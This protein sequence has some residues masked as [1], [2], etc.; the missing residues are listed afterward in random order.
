MEKMMESQFLT[1]KW[2]FTVDKAL[3]ISPSVWWTCYEYFPGFCFCDDG[4][5]WNTKT[6]C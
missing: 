6:P 4:K 2:G 5:V 3:T 1:H